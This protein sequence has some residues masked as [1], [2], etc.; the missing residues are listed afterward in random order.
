MELF[1]FDRGVWS[2]SSGAGVADGFFDFF[3]SVFFLLLDRDDVSDYFF[4]FDSVFFL[5]LDRD[6]GVKLFSRDIMSYISD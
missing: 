4:I 2:S 5:L 1:D 6:F 3:D